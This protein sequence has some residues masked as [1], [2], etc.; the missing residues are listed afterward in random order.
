MG[1]GAI[2]DWFDFLTPG[3][4]RW[5][6]GQRGEP[7]DSCT[8]ARLEDVETRTF[9]LT[10]VRPRRRTITRLARSVGPNYGA[11]GRQC[12]FTLIELLVV[13][14]IIAI[15]AGLL[16]PVLVRAKSKAQGVQCLSNLKQH[17][18]AWQMYAG[19]SHERL[20][21][22]HSCIINQPGDEFTWAQGFMDWYDPTKAD[23]WDPSLHIAKSP[24]MRYLGNSFAVWKCPADKST[25]LR[26]GQHVPRVR[27]YSMGIWVGGDVHCPIRELWDPWVLYRQVGDIVDP[28]P[29]RSFIFLDERAES[30]NDDCFELDQFKRWD[31]APNNKIVSWPALYHGGAGSLAFADGHCEGR[32]WKDL[33]TTP[34]RIPPPSL[35]GT[36]SPSPNN[37]DVTWLQERSTRRHD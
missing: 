31:D 21:Y 20:P 28:G 30:I 4:G 35:P 11:T 16:L 19:D 3:T 8:L 33:R 29:S 9:R 26:N 5:F 14:A 24:V 27:S 22:S 13:I 36:P 2:E 25:G 34:A 18:L 32:K 12:S 6:G 15:L 17:I 10:S 37:P 23:N 1:Q 7:G